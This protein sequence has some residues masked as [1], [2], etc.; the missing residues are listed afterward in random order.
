MTTLRAAVLTIIAVVLKSLP[1]PAQRLPDR[2]RCRFRPRQRL[3]EQQGP[4]TAE[5]SRK[6]RDGRVVDG[7]RVGEGVGGGVIVVDRDRPR[8]GQML[9]PPMMTLLLLR[10]TAFGIDVPAMA[11]R[12]PAISVMIL[13]T[14]PR[15]VAPLPVLLSTVP[16]PT[17]KTPPPSVTAPVKPGLALGRLRMPVPRARS[18]CWG[19]RWSSRPCR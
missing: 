19:C 5:G 10:I 12:V 14:P 15:A 9:V 16:L 2:M 7:E 18:C 13:P 8:E 1:V 3:R 4:G 17:C 11:E 6:S